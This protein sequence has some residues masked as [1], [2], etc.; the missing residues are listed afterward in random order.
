MRVAAARPTGMFLLFVP[1][2]LGG[3]LLPRASA[4]LARS[5]SARS[6][7]QSRYE[8]LR[9]RVM[10]S[11][12][13]VDWN[14]LRQTAVDAGLEDGFD[15]HPVR[16][17]VLR[18]L[19]AGNAQ[20]ALG[21]AQTIIAHNMANPEGHLL[22]MMADQQLGQ[23][24]AADAEHNIVAAIVQSI[25]ASGD[26][27]SEQ[28]ALATVSS[29]EE[30]FVVD[31][32]LGADTESQALVSRDGSSFDRRTIRGEDGSERV[33]WFRVITRPVTVAEVLP[34]R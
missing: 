25:M 13:S 6:L 12:L 24:P 30:E 3:C 21:G 8:T 22:A 4:Q 1:A 18:D 20:A 5:A 2:L 28:R 26:G 34:L 16:Q 9:T 23:E 10:A 29:S 32:V 14:E 17:R 33:L 11:D 7:A 15:W 19:D 27:F 31:M